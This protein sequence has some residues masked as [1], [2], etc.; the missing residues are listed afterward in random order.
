MR[1]LMGTLALILAGTAPLRGAGAQTW[2]EKPVHIIVAFT[3]GSATDVIARAMSN[4]LSARLGQPVIIENRPG[5]G[6]TIA[7]AFVA[8][9]PPDGY[10]LL[11]DS[12][13]HTVNPWIYGNLPYDTVK[14]LKGVS[15]LARQTNVLVVSPD[16]SWKTVADLVNQ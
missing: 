16:R 15:V 11:V 3:P 4:E 7:N 5:A 10:T 12:S 1:L 8:K 2:P 6:G 9:A 14:D 13:G